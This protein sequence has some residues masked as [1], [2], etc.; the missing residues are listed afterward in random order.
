MTFFRQI[1]CAQPAIDTFFEQGKNRT[2]DAAELD[3]YLFNRE[4]R[5]DEAWGPERHS[6]GSEKL[7]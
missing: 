2:L 3:F 6:L 7:R 1:P 4:V 5:M